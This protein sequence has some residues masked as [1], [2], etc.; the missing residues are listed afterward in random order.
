MSLKLEVCFCLL[1]CI[2][3]KYPVFYIS[4]KVRV[5]VFSYKCN[6]LLACYY[7]DPVE[8]EVTS[9]SRTGKPI[10]SRVLRL[11]PGS[12]KFEVS[13]QIILAQIFRCTDS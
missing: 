10:A 4:Q 9:D 1:Y 7:V 12:V 5:R 11:E 8:F 6:A 2:Y 3:C 13:N